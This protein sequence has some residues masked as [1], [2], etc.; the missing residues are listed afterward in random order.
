MKVGNSRSRP[1]SPSFS[2]IRSSVSEPL[3]Q[4]LCASSRTAL[5]WAM[6]Y[7][8]SSSVRTVS[9]SSPPAGCTSPSERLKRSWISSGVMLKAGAVVFRE[10]PS[11]VQNCSELQVESCNLNDG[12]RRQSNSEISGGLGSDA[13]Y[14]KK[15]PL[16]AQQ[17]VTG[18]GWNSGDLFQWTPRLMRVLILV[19]QDPGG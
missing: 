16:P 6:R 10:A 13:R 18:F 12:N 8:F 7:C 19:S 15:V 17:S 9:S 11:K 4:A 3:T 1:P 14:N 5:R 2:A